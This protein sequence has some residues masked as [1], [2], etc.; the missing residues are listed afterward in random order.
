MLEYTQKHKPT[1]TH[2]RSTENIQ[3]QTHPHKHPPT[4]KHKDIGTCHHTHTHTKVR[5]LLGAR[6]LHTRGS[7]LLL[8]I[9]VLLKKTLM[10]LEINPPL[11]TRTENEG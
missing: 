8:T 7:E 11:G 3:P 2:T 5:K 6:K 9:F 10:S 4:N 1:Y